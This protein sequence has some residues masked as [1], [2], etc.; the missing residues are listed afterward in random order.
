MQDNLIYQKPDN[1][2]FGA[3]SDLGTS[4]SKCIRDRYYEDEFF[5][6]IL[7]DPSGFTNFRVD[8]GLIHFVSDRFEVITIPDIQAGGTEHLGMAD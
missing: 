2:Q 3:S 8:G 1:C 4:F 6:S 7:K 5:D